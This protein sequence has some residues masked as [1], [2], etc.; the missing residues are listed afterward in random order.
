MVRPHPDLH[1]SF[2]KDKGE[3]LLGPIVICGPSNIQFS[4]DV[5]ICLPH[6]LAMESRRWEMVV[7]TTDELHVND[8]LSWWDVARFDVSR[9][10][11]AGKCHL[12]PSCVRLN[13]RRFGMYALRG[14]PR[15]LQ[16][17]VFAPA[18]LSPLWMVTFVI[19]GHSD[20]AVKVS[21]S[22]AEMMA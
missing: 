13:V 14:S 1:L 21:E 9:A 20:E 4:H 2:N 11:S 17:M 3:C 8:Q 6:C 19:V 18:K 16:V 15:L 12:E 5:E 10:L 22:Q 7:M